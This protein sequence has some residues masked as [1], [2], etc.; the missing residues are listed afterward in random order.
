MT[1]EVS[2]IITLQTL[3]DTALHTDVLNIVNTLLPK[4]VEAVADKY[5]SEYAELENTWNDLCKKVH[6]IKNK[7]LIVSY[8]PITTSSKNDQ[9]IVL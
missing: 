9:Y 2:S 3:N 1:T 4:W 6:A 8:L 7:I 5:A